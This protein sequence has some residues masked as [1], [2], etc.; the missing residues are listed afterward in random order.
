MVKASDLLTVFFA[1]CENSWIGERFRGNTMRGIMCCANRLC[2]QQFHRVTSTGPLPS[3]NPAAPRRTPKNPEEPRRT[4]EETPG[5]RPLRT[6]CEANFL[7]EPRRGFCPSDGDP[8][9][10]YKSLGVRTLK[11]KNEASPS[12]QPWAY[13]KALELQNGAASCCQLMADIVKISHDPVST[14]HP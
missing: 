14:P 3:E 5:K 13:K 6:F 11:S 10:L 8:P 7:G 12:G 9:E 2:L 4:L 1:H